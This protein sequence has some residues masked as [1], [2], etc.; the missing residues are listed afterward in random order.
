M[1]NEL[2][3]LARLSNSW[4][5]SPLNL[6]SLMPQ[7]M[8]LISLLTLSVVISVPSTDQLSLIP[9]ARRPITRENCF[10]RPPLP[11][12]LKP[13]LLLNWP[14]TTTPATSQQ[15]ILTQTVIV[16]PKR[17]IN[18]AKRHISPTHRLVRSR[19]V[20]ISLVTTHLWQLVTAS[21]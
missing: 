21:P 15:F 8:E 14:T 1:D 19:R 20:S 11:S 12:V 10:S 16:R 18:Y 7:H 5:T 17:E 9:T 2:W 4:L 6:G 13:E 3:P